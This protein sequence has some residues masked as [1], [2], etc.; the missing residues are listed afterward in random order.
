LSRPV[1][2]KIT[3]LR[4]GAKGWKEGK[5]LCRKTTR[6]QPVGSTESACKGKGEFLEKSG[7]KKTLEGELCGE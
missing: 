1:K 7:T 6:G 4:T 5:D 2:G 3:D